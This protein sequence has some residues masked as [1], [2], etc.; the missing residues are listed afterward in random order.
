M[1]KSLLAL[2]LA[3]ATLGAQAANVEVYGVVDS[4]LMYA[5]QSTDDVAGVADKD[6]LGLA[7]GINAAS[8]FGFKGTEDLGNGMKVSFKL[9]NGFNSD[10]GTFAA[11]NTLFSREASLTV[12]GAFG[13]VSFGRMGGL[14]SSAGTYDVFALY[15]DAFDGGDNNVGSG[16]AM[17]GRYDNMVTYASPEFAGAKVYAQYSFQQAGSENDKAGNNDRFAALGATYNVGNLGLVAVV[18]SFQYAN[19]NVGTTD[20]P[21]F[22]PEDDGLTFN[23]GANYDCGFAKTFAG[24]QVARNVKDMANIGTAV[25]FLG[26]GE[27]FNTVNGW[28]G[29]A[30]TVGTQFPVGAGNVTAAF[31]YADAEEA[32]A[33][34]ADTPKAEATYYGLSARYVYPLSARTSVYTGAGWSKTTGEYKGTWKLDAEMHTVQ[35]YAGLTHAF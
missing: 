33:H 2:A 25:A 21:A 7:S 9:E 34:Y 17:S 1:K 4:G 13:D 5:K 24:F 28:D 18:E 19:G 35:A 23:V 20:R 27:E 30:A 10:T 16:F 15:T 22:N 6:T 32:D 14:A 8:R 3:A 29:W 26:G 12:S 31:Y 11:D